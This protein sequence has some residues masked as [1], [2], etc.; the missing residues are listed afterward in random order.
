[1][2]DF[3]VWKLDG[4]TFCLVLCGIPTTYVMVNSHAPKCIPWF[5][6]N[7][8]VQKRVNFLK[9]RH[10]TTVYNKI[11]TYAKRE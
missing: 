8:H 6:L 3:L 9:Q 10:Q 1:M 7:V 4:K 11:H 5:F 2:I